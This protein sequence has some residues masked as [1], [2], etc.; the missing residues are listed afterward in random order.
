MRIR[1]LAFAGLGPFRSPQCIDFDALE[2]VGIYLI[3]GRTG[4]GKSTILDAISFA[5]YGSVPRFDGTATR[6][7]SDHSAPEDETFAELDFEA[8]GRLY[9]IRRSP[10]YERPAKRGGGTT[11]QAAKVALLEHVDG[12]WTGLSSSA[13]ETGVDIGHI[14]GLTKDQFLQVI[15]LAQN[16][17][18]EFLLAKND[19]R[20]RLLRT[21]FATERYEQLRRRLL[22]QRQQSGAALEEERATVTALADE[23]RRIAGADETGAAD[24]PWFSGL[25]AR[26]EPLLESARAEATTADDADR[27]A[28]TALDAARI[29]RRAQERRSRALREAEEL[30]VAEPAAAE[31]RE[32]IESPSCRHRAPGAAQRTRGAHGGRQR[33]GEARGGG[34][35]V[36]RGLRARARSHRRGGGGRGAHGSPR[37]TRRRAGRRAAPARGERPRRAGA[38]G[39]RGGGTR[40][41]DRRERGTRAA[42]AARCARERGD[43]PHSRGHGGREPCG[44]ARRPRPADRPARRAGRRRGDPRRRARRSRPCRPAARG[45]RRR[46][47]PPRGAA[48][49]RICRRASPPRCAR[50]SPA[51]SADRRSTRRPRATAIPLRSARRISIGHASRSSA[52]PPRW[53]PPAPTRT[54]PRSP[55]PRSTSAPDARARTSSRA[56][57]P[58]LAGAWRPRG[59][60]PAAAR[61]CAASAPPS[62]RVPRS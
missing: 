39:P 58:T 4:A 35:A 36:P 3:A 23:A 45:A 50:T 46:A 51:R 26:L 37:R 53:T 16:R 28:R 2:D 8:A 40:P 47:R 31:H 22:E 34:R 5:L 27:E 24:L 61:R 38:G 17:F 49:R 54:R 41:R 7:R 21:L 59:V 33:G 62:G 1:R 14:V 48:L 44:G 55:G 6:L 56:P 15:L 20:Q 52:P 32:R 30:A 18:H 10:E 57:A 11:R 42:G 29:L 19:D 43:G 12:E 9:R 13:R 25:V 60:P